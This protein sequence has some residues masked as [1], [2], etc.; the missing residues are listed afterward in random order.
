MSTLVFIN[1]EQPSPDYLSNDC[2]N[3]QIDSTEDD[4]GSIGADEVTA[5]PTTFVGH[6][7]CEVGIQNQV[8]YTRTASAYQNSV[9]KQRDK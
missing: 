5:L 9:I 4:G 3:G 2:G 6:D 8:H 1:F 7:L